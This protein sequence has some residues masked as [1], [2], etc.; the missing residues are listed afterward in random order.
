MAGV[1]NI[2]LSIAKGEGG[3]RRTV[4]VKYR[5]NFSQCEVTAGAAFVET[6]ALRGLDPISDDDLATIYRS[7]V[8]ADRTSMDRTRTATVSRRALDED[9]DTVIFGWVVSA[10]EDEIYAR[11]TLSPF[12]SSGASGNSNVVRGQFGAGGKD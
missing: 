10:D 6:V 8:K 9:G 7:C 2:S 11:V 4:T 5:L 3:D 1:S 12:V